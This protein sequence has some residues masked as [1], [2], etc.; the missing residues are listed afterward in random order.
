MVSLHSGLPPSNPFS[1]VNIAIE[2]VSPTRKT[3]VVTVPAGEVAAEEK[4][5]VGEISQAVRLPGFR[6][7]KAPVDMVK[8]RYTKEIS[9]ELQ[10]KVTT[11]A[12]EQAVKESKV[13]IF[14]AV[15]VDADPVVLG[16]DAVL[17]ITVDVEPEFALPEYKGLPIM[18]APNEVTD[19]DV[20][21]AITEL[22][23]Q[24]ADYTV[25]DRAAAAGDFVRLNYIGT[26]DGKPI[27]EISPEHPIFG[28]IKGY[29]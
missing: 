24:R 13:N 28:N 20:D 11:K 14:A 19:A 18:V 7:G 16:K 29:L 5:V 27:A 4:A 17:K 8:R 25:V 9:D 22:R 26:L 1:T 15:N 21:A 23:N 3:L 12:Y 2:E 10:R 6:P